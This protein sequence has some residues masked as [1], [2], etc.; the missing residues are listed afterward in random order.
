M[1]TA[2]LTGASFEIAEVFDGVNDGETSNLFKVL[3][4]TGIQVISDDGIFSRSISPIVKGILE[5]A[6]R[7]FVEK[8]FPFFKLIFNFRGPTNFSVELTSIELVSLLTAAA[9]NDGIGV[10]FAF[11]TVVD[12]AAVVATALQVFLSGSILGSNTAK[13][14]RRSY[15]VFKRK[16][17]IA[18]YNPN[19]V[20]GDY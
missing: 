10:F 12:A 19:G 15:C 18:D 6:W 4:E 8:D 11:S 2:V 16:N 17:K 7:N 5:F 9:A 1:G 14:R 3:L 20:P 13:Q